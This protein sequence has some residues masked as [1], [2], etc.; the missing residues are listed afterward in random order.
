MCFLY[1]F[2][3]GPHLFLDIF[4]HIF[5]NQNLYL[6]SLIVC[7][8]FIS[9]FKSFSF[10]P[11]SFKSSIYNKWLI[12]LSVPCTR[13]PQSVLFSSF[14]NG[15]S[16]MQKSNGERE[17]PWNIPLLIWIGCDRII[18]CFVL[19]KSLVFHFSIDSLQNLTILLFT[20]TNSIDFSTQLCGTLSNALLLLLLLLLLPH[21][22]LCWNDIDVSTFHRTHSCSLC[23]DISTFYRILTF[24]TL[25]TR[26][27]HLLSFQAR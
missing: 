15:M 18:S 24:V 3:F 11:S 13:Y 21:E 1:A 22:P 10:L 25:V 7:T 23:I 26:E 8:F 27:S 6:S 19:K 20:P 5:L 17:S 2:C 9:F 4:L 16:A 12:F 14:V